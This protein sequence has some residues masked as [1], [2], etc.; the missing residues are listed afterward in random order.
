MTRKFEL[1]TGD[2]RAETFVKLDGIDIA[3][4]VR[5]LYISVSTDSLPRV[6]LALTPL[7]S[8][9]TLDAEVILQIASLRT[10]LEES[11]LQALEDLLN[12]KIPSGVGEAITV[13]RLEAIKALV[14]AAKNVSDHGS[15][16]P[17]PE[18]T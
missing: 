11:L 2:T 4:A 7:N 14:E 10:V 13:T 18:S 3:S 8:H 16:S 12:C 6:E 1:R 5:A 17:R 9:V 15:L